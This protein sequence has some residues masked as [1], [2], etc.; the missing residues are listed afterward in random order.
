MAL[1]QDNLRGLENNRETHL[2]AEVIAALKQGLSDRLV[3][4]VLFGSRARGGGSEISDWDLLV[5]ARDLPE[6]F[7]KRHLWLKGMLPDGWRGQ[8]SILSRTPK[9]FEAYL[10]SLYLDIALDG[11]LLHDSSG[12]AAERL[13]RIRRLIEKHGLRREQVNGDLMWRWERFPGFNW[14]LEWDR[15]VI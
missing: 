8:V 3:A 11:I 7:F 12:Y 9:E 2:L 5:I 10:A 6:R 1:M 15:P 4:I 14:T 13:A